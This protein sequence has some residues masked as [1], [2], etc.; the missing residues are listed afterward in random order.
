MKETWKILTRDGARWVILARDE[1][2][3]RTMLREEARR[4]GLD[5]HI[6]SLTLGD[7]EKPLDTHHDV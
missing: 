7:E 2:E 6:I 4:L 5:D 3:A 1:A